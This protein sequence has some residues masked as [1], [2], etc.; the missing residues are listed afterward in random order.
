MPDVKPTTARIVL[1]QPKNRGEKPWPAIVVEV[2]ESAKGDVLCDLH[3]FATRG[4]GPQSLILDVPFS[5]IPAP[6]ACTFPPRA[7]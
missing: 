5:M 7:E 3:P 2:R 6:G 1:Y 4:H